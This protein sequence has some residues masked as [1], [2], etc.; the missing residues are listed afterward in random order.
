[1]QIAKKNNNKQAKSIRPVSCQ[2]TESLHGR[3]V[4]YSVI[5]LSQV[6]WGPEHCGMQGHL[7]QQGPIC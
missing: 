2:A 5:L 1:M 6:Q 7:V 3:S 4:A